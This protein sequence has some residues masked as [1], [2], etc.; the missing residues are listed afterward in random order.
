MAGGC[1]PL[2]SVVLRLLLAMT[3]QDGN[4]IICPELEGHR[5]GTS[6]PS[7]QARK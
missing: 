6:G 4:Q 7:P 3:F 5:G 2:L 1:K